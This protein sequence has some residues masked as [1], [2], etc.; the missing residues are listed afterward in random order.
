MWSGFDVISLLV[1]ATEYS[2]SYIN[3][4]CKKAVSVI[5]FC[6]HIKM[7]E[8][9]FRHVHVDDSDNFFYLQCT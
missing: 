5:Y 2:F 7:F 9:C 3:N 1:L 4:I 6:I 8:D